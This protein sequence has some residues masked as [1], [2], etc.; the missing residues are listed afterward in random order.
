MSIQPLLEAVKARSTDYIV[1]KSV[2]C[3]DYADSKGIPSG[4]SGYQGLIL[5]NFSITTILMQNISI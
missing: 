5:G 2:T 4:T 1:E 3:T